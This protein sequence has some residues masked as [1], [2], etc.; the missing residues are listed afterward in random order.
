MWNWG[1]LS[2]IHVQG[3][4]LPIL[5]INKNLSPPGQDWELLKLK[6]IGWT[7]DNKLWL[8]TVNSLCKDLIIWISW[9][10]DLLVN[11]GFIENSSNFE[12]FEQYKNICGNCDSIDNLI[13]IQLLNDGK[14]DRN[15]IILDL[16]KNIS[17]DNLKSQFLK[18]GC[19]YNG[20]TEMGFSYD[21]SD[22]YFSI[23]Y[24]QF[25]SI[26]IIPKEYK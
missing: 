2:E 9:E 20:Y 10:T 19:Q 11:K 7:S 24:N 26:L 18:N 22:A 12:E 14:H 25:N 15:V 6:E 21:C 16:G 5:S 3:E 8:I 23:K 17:L 4:T 1:N 13:K